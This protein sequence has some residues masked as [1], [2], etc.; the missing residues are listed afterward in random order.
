MTI[1]GI[2]PSEAA[3]DVKSAFRNMQEFEGFGEPVPL[4]VSND[5]RRLDGT[6]QAA[7]TE[8]SI[9][10]VNSSEADLGDPML[11][12]VVVP[13]TREQDTVSDITAPPASRWCS[14]L[15]ATG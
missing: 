12:S 4:I 10:E 8:A 11:R 2:P 5:H 1:P 13:G 6:R 3:R 9:V 14:T 15:S 7:T